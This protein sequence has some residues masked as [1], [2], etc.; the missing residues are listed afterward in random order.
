MNIHGS[1][2]WYKMSSNIYNL[3]I[4]TPEKYF[5]TCGPEKEAETRKCWDFKA[6]KSYNLQLESQ[7][8]NE[9]VEVLHNGLMLGIIICCVPSS[10]AL[11]FNNC[12]VLL[13]QELAR[14]GRIDG[15]TFLQRTENILPRK[16][17]GSD[18]SMDIQLKTISVNGAPIF[19]DRVVLLLDDVTTSGNSMNACSQLL[20]QN[21]AKKVFKLGIWKTVHPK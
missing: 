10:K 14:R 21:G 15:S 19:K 5:S 18:R 1:S 6:V 16:Q 17:K 3:R 9:T 20:L 11:D 8:F 12:V 13:V 2:L 4:Y 7:I